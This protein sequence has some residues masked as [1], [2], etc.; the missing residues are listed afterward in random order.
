MTIKLYHYS[1][2]DERVDKASLL[3]TAT[4]IT[5]DEWAGDQDVLNP[6]F[7]ISSNT[8][9][10]YNYAYVTEYGRYYFVGPPIWLANNNWRLNLSI[11][12]LYTYKT[13]I[14]NQSGVIQYSN[15]GSSMYY[16]PRLVYNRDPD[17]V[18]AEA[19]S[20]KKQSGIPFIL[21]RVRYFDD[22][23]LHT[24]NTN[25]PDLNTRYYIMSPEGYRSFVNQYALM[26][27]GITNEDIA[28]A[29][30]KTIMDCSLIFYLDN[31]PVSRGTTDL[32][33]NTPEINMLIGGGSA[34]GWSFTIPYTDG[35]PNLW[36]YEYDTLT[37][38]VR[39]SWEIEPATYW[40]RKAKRTMYIPFVGTMSFD[41]DMMGQG[42][43]TAMYVG[44]ELR[45]DLASNA[46]IMVPGVSAITTGPDAAFDR[47]YPISAQ[48]CP[49]MFTAP[50]LSDASFENAD[51]Q[52]RQQ[53]LGLAGTAISGVISAIATEGASVPMT[54]ASLGMGIANMGLQQER[55]GYNQ[56]TSIV[57]HG[58]ANGGSQD[59]AFVAYPNGSIVYP[60]CLMESLINPPAPGWSNFQDKFGKPDGAY[61]A[62]A[63]MTG[64]VRFAD[65]QLTGMSTLSLTERND[66]R[67]LLMQGVIL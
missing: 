61:R 66:I 28:V 24:I 53:L 9:P 13:Q 22:N 37:P 20:T 2:E 30:G 26:I 60:K 10:D 19:D 8:V 32:N 1:G 64:Y 62:L 65:I 44:V 67:A 49:N 48:R 41:L 23:G 46:Y 39:I 43:S 3:G 7:I 40:Q 31:W 25:T 18:R 54:A 59:I 45:Y 11:D 17:F 34:G 51:Q 42:A 16:D 55:V 57:L 6:S 21:M 58:T 27:T 4:T 12:P 15:Q 50:F 38:S 56:A 52:A 35:V 63:G 36:M 33:F 47:I 5:G 14:M 29:I